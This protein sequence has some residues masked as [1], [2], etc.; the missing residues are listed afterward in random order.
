[1]TCVTRVSRAV[2]STAVSRS[3]LAH[4]IAQALEQKRIVFQPLLNREFNWKSAVNRV[5]HMLI[6]QH[7]LQHKR[8]LGLPW[9]PR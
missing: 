7:F 2:W 9:K 1:M 6:A 4:F 8:A 5:P 3:H